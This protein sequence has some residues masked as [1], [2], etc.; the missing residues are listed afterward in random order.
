MSYYVLDIE[1]RPNPV[2]QADA[3][4]WAGVAENLEPPGNYKDER[5]IEEW[6]LREVTKQRDQM[7]L[8]GHAGIV[9]CIG[10]Q[11]LEPDAEPVVLCASEESL[12]AEATVL[13]NFLR[14]MEN[15][16]PTGFVGWNIRGFD[17]P[18]L[19][20][21]VGVHRD[22]LQPSSGVIPLPRAWDRVI[23]LKEILAIGGEGHLDEWQQAFGFPAKEVTGADVLKI[24]LP[25]LA[26]HCHDDIV[27]TAEIAHRTQWA[28]SR[29]R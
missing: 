5:K 6:R 26:K 10:F 3:D 28:W 14:R 7:A 21:R 25:A 12:T 19:I 18:F 11:D 2:I 1:T 17:I 20:G 22:A 23:D 4:Y 16:R 15:E 8:R 29:A 13:N 27:A 9:V 24:P